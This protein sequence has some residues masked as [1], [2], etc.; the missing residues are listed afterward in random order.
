LPLTEYVSFIASYTFNIDNVTLDP[1]NY[2]TDSN[3]DG[4]R[5]NSVGDTCDP[6]QSSRYLC[7]ALGKRTSSILGAT[8]IYD[9]LDSRYRPSRGALVT[10][11]LEFAGLG[12]SV[13]YAKF[14]VNAAQY[15]PIGKGF[16]FSLHGE[17]GIVESFGKDDI[18][19]TDRF[20]L[21][22]PQIRGFDI[23]GVGPRILRKRV[24]SD[25]ADT[26]GAT[27]LIDDNPQNFI[28]DDALG[29]RYYY[30]ARAE[31]EIPLG[32]GAREL[33]LRPSIF[34][35]AGAVWG[36]RRPTLLTSPFPNGISQPS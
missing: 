35:D 34:I 27:P 20:F 31:L 25:P 24:N 21:G 28:S 18:R 11:N 5:G 32:S 10:Y 23:R 19:L 33:G 14:R 29:G 4:I 7:E 22:E 13:K 17:G 26:T 8:L 30:L 1:F 9:H 2:F 36:V 15:F 6:F 16:I 12:G 3:F